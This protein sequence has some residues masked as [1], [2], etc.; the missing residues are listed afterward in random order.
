[1]AAHRGR[2]HERRVECRVLAR[3][4]WLR[5]DARTD[6]AAV[7]RRKGQRSAAHRRGARQA[8]TPLKASD[9]VPLHLADVTY[10]YGHPLAGEDGPVLGFAI[11]HPDGVMLV[12][13][14]IGEGNAWIDE[15]YRP[16]RREVREALRAS[17][18]APE[19]VG[20]IVNPHLP[21]AHCGQNRAFAGVPVVVQRAER[22][23]AR[24]EG[25][26]FVGWLEFPGARFALVDGTCA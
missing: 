3:V 2:G 21:F 24:L 13:T 8:R 14:G 17:G 16:R 19:S 1:R 22:E 15:H 20:T 12:D 9:V 10:P 5:A 6:R 4:T 23:L 18:L 7:R 25:Q 11:R 26:P